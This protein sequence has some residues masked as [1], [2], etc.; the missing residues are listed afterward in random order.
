MTRF[1]TLAELNSKILSAF[2]GVP[3]AWSGGSTSASYYSPTGIKDPDGGNIG[4]FLVYV[5]SAAGVP[6]A[7]AGFQ[8]VDSGAA[9]PIGITFPAGTDRRV[10]ITEAKDNYP[11]QISSGTYQAD[12]GNGGQFTRYWYLPAYVSASK[13]I[14]Y[15]Q[16]LELDSTLAPFPMQQGK[17]P[18]MLLTHLNDFT[19]SKWQW[20]SDRKVTEHDER[21]FSIYR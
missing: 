20:K 7:K 4:K 5:Y 3:M 17:K 10:L 6:T 18:P 19:E 21:P 11:K 15:L 12:A 8:R 14:A 16:A 2:Q 9:V 13:F 1:I